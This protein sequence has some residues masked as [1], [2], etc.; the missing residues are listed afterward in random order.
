M[1]TK[2]AAG[3]ISIALHVLVCSEGRQLL[4]NCVLLQLPP[5]ARAALQLC[6]FHG[7]CK[8]CIS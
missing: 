2:T 7:C 4:K 6:H 3:A 5:Q 1:R 8:A